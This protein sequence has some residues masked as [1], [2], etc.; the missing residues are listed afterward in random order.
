M[1]SLSRIQKI[2]AFLRICAILALVLTACLLGFDSQT[3][4]IFYIEKKA[5]F[6]DLRALV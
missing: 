5:S 6:K 4:V 2:E 1:E 3:K